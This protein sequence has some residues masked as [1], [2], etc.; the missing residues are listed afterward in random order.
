MRRRVGLLG[1]GVVGGRRGCS[2]VVCGE[3]MW[4]VGGIGCFVRFL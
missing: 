4:S 1:G 3:I 2:G